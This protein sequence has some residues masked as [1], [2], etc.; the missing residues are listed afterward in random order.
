M[1]YNLV[2]T[3]MRLLV[4]VSFLLLETSVTLGQDAREI[5]H[6]MLKTEESIPPAMINMEVS[7]YYAIDQ[8]MGR[9]AGIKHKIQVF[10]DGERFDVIN[11]V[12]FRETDEKDGVFEHSSNNRI[13]WD[14]KR[15]MSRQ[16][17]GY[18]TKGYFRH[19]KEVLSWRVRAPYL[20]GVL[21]Y[22]TSHFADN[23]LKS[24]N[25]N[26]RLQ[27]ETINDF[28]CYVIEG[29]VGGRHYT[30]WVDIENGYKYRKAIVEEKLDPPLR[31]DSGKDII[32]RVFETDGVKIEAIE[33]H[34]ITT[35]IKQTVSNVYADGTTT[36]DHHTAK[37]N[38][39]KWN[40][41]FEGLNAFKMDMPNGTIVMDLDF[42]IKYMWNDGK[43][44]TLVDKDALRVIENVVDQLALSNSTSPF[45][46]AF[47]KLQSDPVVASEAKKV[48][49][50]VSGQSNDVKKP[51]PL[52]LASTVLFMGCCTVFVCWC[53]WRKKHV[54][55]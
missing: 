43:L 50:E 17:S 26:I 8:A 18:G 1:S 24:S 28:P 36:K 52:G 19:K 10:N 30:I 9:N 11:D 27:Q 39:V 15:S 33:D 29:N 37:I 3:S 47:I 5:I 54:S 45:A 41:D 16:N 44:Q 23:L 2:K 22:G 34:Y 51:I 49:R 14:G 32:S 42:N 25:L 40:P 13:I 53:I 48:P 12:S 20:Y 46:K 55:K 21:D 38:H 7:Q 4:F 31:S 6:K 35:E